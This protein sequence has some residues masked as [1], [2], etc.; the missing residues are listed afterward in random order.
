MRSIRVS[1]KRPT[2]LE[3][4]A[5]AIAA[6]FLIVSALLA[7]VLVGINPLPPAGRCVGDDSNNDMVTVGS[8]PEMELKLAKCQS[9]Y[10]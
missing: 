7:G 5:L 1:P 4:F 6:F 8:S 9:A 10:C 3:Y 2:A